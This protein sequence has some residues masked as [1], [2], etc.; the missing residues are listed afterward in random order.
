MIMKICNK[1]AFLNV[2]INRITNIIMKF[3]HCSDLHL[4]KRQIGTAEYSKKRFEDFFVSFEYFLDFAI[5]K[6]LD[7]ILLTGDIF[8]KKELSPEILERTER[9]FQKAVANHLK[10]ILI[11]G[12]HDNISN[13]L[14]SWLIYLINKGLA[15]RPYFERV[16]DKYIFHSIE[17]NNI[18]FF[19]LGY[20][21]AFA[22][23]IISEFAKYLESN[24]SDQQRIALMHTAIVNNDILNGTISSDTIKLLENKLIYIGG[25][26]IHSFTKYPAAEPY[27]FTPGCPEFWD[28]NEIGK[29]KG[30]VLFDTDTK[31]FEFIPAKSRRVHQLKLN[32]SANDMSELMDEISNHF[33]GLDI[34]SGE[35]LAKIDIN[36][37]NTFLIDYD[38]IESTLSNIGILKTI[39]KYNPNRNE[40]ISLE[41]FSTVDDI[42][43]EII[44]GWGIF[45]N[46]PDETHKYLK[47]FKTNYT[48][49]MNEAFAE[50]FDLM[51]E[52]VMKGAE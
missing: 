52:S 25:G 29:T 8:D 51:L 4:G 34:E 30:A 21:G 46:K 12:N 38:L 24:P 14:D 42:E 5:D 10:I 39:I 40:A 27:F 13:P 9:L 45:A 26:H 20:M 33:K 2:I 23:E 15:E 6:H 16:E 17:L 32:T 22:N 47:I 35:D 44:K 3:L 49:N 48:E 36:S 7:A 41:E 18:E 19:G 11:E 1:F 43:M 28:I 31:I 50:N 37:Q